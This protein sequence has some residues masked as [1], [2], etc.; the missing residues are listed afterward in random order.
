MRYPI[1]ATTLSLMLGG[2]LALADQGADTPKVA[3]PHPTQMDVF[4][5][6]D[7]AELTFANDAELQKLAEWAKC[8]KS[9]V[10][11]LE[12]HADPRG[13]VEYN[14]DLS[15][16]RAKAVTERLV[17]LGTPRDRIIVTVYGELGD[18]RET[19]AQDRRVSMLPTKETAIIGTR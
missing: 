14:T 4:F 11:T 3:P 6:T 19:F 5:E 10:I 1:L 2:G 9:N 13:P 7:S 16:R 8:K 17:E 12:G 15:E 18:R